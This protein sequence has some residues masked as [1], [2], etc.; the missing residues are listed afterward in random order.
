MIQ[1]VCVADGARSSAIAGNTRYSIVTS[2]PSRKVGSASIAIPAHARA[3]EG[4][5]A[6]PLINTLARLIVVVR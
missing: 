6:C 5:A 2:S 4:A 3:P 1:S